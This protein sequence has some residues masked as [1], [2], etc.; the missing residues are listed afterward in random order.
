M[1][2][3]TSAPALVQILDRHALHFPFSEAV[4]HIDDIVHN[5]IFQGFFRKGGTHPGGAEQD[6]L[7][8]C[9]EDIFVIGALR[10][11]SEFQHAARG[12]IGR[13]SRPCVFQFLNIAQ[14]Y[15]SRRAGIA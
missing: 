13:G 5:R 1:R 14:I 15:Q 9:A 3:R 8:V 4:F 2:C 7:A 12:M 10:V 11:S 6:Q